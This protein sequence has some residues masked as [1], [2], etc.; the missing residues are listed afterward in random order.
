MSENQPQAPL[1]ADEILAAPD[2]Y[3]QF[4]QGLFNRTGDLSKDFTHAVLGILTEC[5][6]YR[7]AIDQVHAIEEA[8][9]QLFFVTALKIVLGEH[10][11]EAA[12][13]EMSKRSAEHLDA[14]LQTWDGKPVSD[15]L[16]DQSVYAMDVCKRW[17]GYGKEPTQ[18]Q[19]DTLVCRLL[20]VCGVALE[21]G[22]F[23]PLDFDQVQKVNVEKLLERYNGT[24]FSADRAVNRDLANERAILERASA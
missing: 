17:V 14:T 18:D 5:H 21:S 4:V 3:N 23:W 8:G 9:D 2:G 10:L 1:T 20:A 22:P 6:E 12:F 7:N 13:L 16:L 19:L 24:R 11:G 15:V